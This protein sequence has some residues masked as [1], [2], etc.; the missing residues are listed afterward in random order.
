MLRVP[1]SKLPAEEQFAKHLPLQASVWDVLSDFSVVYKKH[2]SFSKV[3]PLMLFVDG[4]LQVI[5][6]LR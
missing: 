1:P 4:I 5:Q 6:F 2:F 3:T